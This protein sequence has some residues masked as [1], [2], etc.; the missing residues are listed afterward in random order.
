MF[1]IKPPSPLEISSYYWKKESLDAIIEIALMLG[2]INPSR[3]DMRQTMDFAE[4]LRNV[5][6]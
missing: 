2:K 1:Q 5:S 3:A 4:Q 6:N